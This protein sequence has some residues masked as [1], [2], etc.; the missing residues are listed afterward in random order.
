M[1]EQP[2]PIDTVQAALSLARIRCAEMPTFNLYASCVAQLEYLLAT[3]TKETPLD[4]AKL[5]T[6]IVGHYGV[7][8]F[9]ET[10]P[11]FSR[12]LVDAQWIATQM[13]EGLRIN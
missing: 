5:R 8:E 10:D 6:I 4:R 2:E 3:L 11:E 1:T 9:E 7:R 13:G 12:A